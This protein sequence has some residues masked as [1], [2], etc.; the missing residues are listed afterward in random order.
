M[1]IIIMMIVDL[2]FVAHLALGDGEA[3]GPAERGV[4][5]RMFWFENVLVSACPIIG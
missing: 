1:I 5:A 2:L 4:C 3:R